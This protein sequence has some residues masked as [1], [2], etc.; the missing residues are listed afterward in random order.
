MVSCS[1]LIKSIKRSTGSVGGEMCSTAAIEV[2]SRLRRGRDQDPVSPVKVS[3]A[4]GTSSCS[5]AVLVCQDKFSDGIRGDA[6]A[7]RL[8]RRAA[9]RLVH[10][11]SIEVSSL[12]NIDDEPVVADLGETLPDDIAIYAKRRDDAV[13]VKGSYLGR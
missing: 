7:D 1:K 12:V 10:C 11:N 6:L 8:E 5:N 2:I 13:F 4:D 3:L 9:R